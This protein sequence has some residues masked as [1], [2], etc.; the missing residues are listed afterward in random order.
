MEVTHTENSRDKGNCDTH[1]QMNEVQLKIMINTLPHASILS[2]DEH[3]T[4]NLE[5][6]SNFSS[7]PSPQSSG[8]IDLL[9]L[10]RIPYEIHSQ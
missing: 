5:R 10:V 6:A 8:I 4:V 3:N 1:G 7:G 2:Y 9:C